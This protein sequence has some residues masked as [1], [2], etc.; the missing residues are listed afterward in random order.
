MV[1]LIRRLSVLT[2]SSKCTPANVVTLNKYLLLSF[3]M[4]SKKQ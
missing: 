4:I 3:F 1:R 2:N